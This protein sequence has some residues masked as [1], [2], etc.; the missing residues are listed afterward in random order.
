MN[1]GCLK[2]Q[3]SEGLLSKLG[4]FPDQRLQFNVKYRQ[5][6]CILMTS[7]SHGARGKR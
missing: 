3:G 5:V 2:T 7:H 1:E 6:V 4:Q